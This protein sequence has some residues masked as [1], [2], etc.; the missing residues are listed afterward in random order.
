MIIDYDYLAKEYIKCF[1]DRTRIYMI[2]NYLKTF[3]NTQKMNVPFHLFPRQQDLCA[4]LGKANNIVTSKP[5]QAGIT[6][7]V[8]A[9]I[10]CEM[11]LADEASPQSALVIGNSIDLAQ[12]M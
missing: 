9:F 6:T 3:D 5:R 7:T 11:I 12:Q 2:Q 1:K 8:A 10:A 4:T